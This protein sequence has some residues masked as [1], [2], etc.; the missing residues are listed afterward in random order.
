MKNLSNIEDIIN[1]I[2]D[3]RDSLKFSDEILPLLSDLF[4]FLKD[5]IPLM[6]EANVSL[7]ESTSKIPT[8]K[9]NLE[10]I[11]KTTETATHEVMDKL[12]SVMEILGTLQKSLTGVNGN[13]DNLKL[14]EKAQDETNEIVYALQF[15]DIVSQ[16]LDHTNRILGAV[17]EKFMEL[18]KSFIKIKNGTTLGKD[19]I[20]AIENE[21]NVAVATESKEYFDKNTEDII[22]K[23]GISQDDIDKLFN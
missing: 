5:T 21:C 9:K 7:K 16:Q 23:D 12:D 18:F 4:M 10:S 17:Y 1:K 8:A 6:L 2:Q 19:I 14:I 11:T 20:S 15:Q 3:I 13:D 22:R